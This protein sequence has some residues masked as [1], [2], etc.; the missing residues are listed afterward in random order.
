MDEEEAGSKYAYL[1]QPIKDLEKNFAVD[2]VGLLEEYT[3]KLAQV[4]AEEADK[5]ENAHRL[6]VLFVL[7][8]CS[9]FNFAE[10]AMLIH[11]TAN[12]YSRKVDL[13]HNQ[14]MNFFECLK[15]TKEK[16]KKGNGMV[17]VL[18]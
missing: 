12:I 16:K 18:C 4:A 8:Q 11:G 2:I 15:T 13:I 9:R 7:Y 6:V 14:A 1:L 5:I 10:A 17:L 3:K